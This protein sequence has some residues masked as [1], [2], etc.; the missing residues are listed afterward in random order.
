ML[1]HS[2]TTEYSLNWLVLRL[3]QEKIN[4][5]YRFG[6]V[7]ILKVGHV[8]CCWLILFVDMMVMLDNIFA[9]S[10]SISRFIYIKCNVINIS[11]VFS[12]LSFFNFSFNVVVFKIVRSTK[13]SQ[14]K[15]LKVF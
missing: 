7:A 13:E 15:T 2:R 14:M 8:L 4:S 3:K 1:S 11:I 9:V 12:S 6:V 10:V 5:K